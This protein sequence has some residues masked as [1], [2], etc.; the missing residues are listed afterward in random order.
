MF[1]VNKF[2]SWLKHQKE[3]KLL[4]HTGDNPSIIINKINDLETLNFYASSLKIQNQINFNNVLDYKFEFLKIL[5]EHNFSIKNFP[6]NWIEFFDIP[7]NHLNYDKV[8]L[9]TNNQGLDSILKIDPYMDYINIDNFKKFYCSTYVYLKNNN[10]NNFELPYSTF[11]GACSGS[12]VKKQQDAI[13][14]DNVYLN[15]IE[16]LSELGIFNSQWYQYVKNIL[17]EKIIYRGEQSFFVS[18]DLSF[19]KAEVVYKRQIDFFATLEKI[20]IKKNLLNN[21]KFKQKLL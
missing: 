17:I 8:K 13:L 9:I 19:P 7:S 10:I 18:S 20:Y 21:Q 4:A 11:N 2:H 12:L 6:K 15:S 16:F 5:Y 14:K 3:K 1:F